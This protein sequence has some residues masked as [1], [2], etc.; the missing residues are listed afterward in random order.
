[1]R[2]NTN[3][4]IA[5]M[6]GVTITLSNFI[7]QADTI[8]MIRTTPHAA[9]L[10]S[11]GA[12]VRRTHFLAAA[13]SLAFSPLAIA[14][15]SA[16]PP[17]RVQH[18]ANFDAERKQANDLYLAGKTLESLPL[19]EDLCRQDS[20]I[21][22]FA[23]RHAGGLFAKLATL[24][25]GQEK[26]AAYNQGTAE[27]HRAQ[28]LGDNSPYVQ[29]LLGMAAKSPI[30]VAVGGPMGGSPL[31]AGYTYTGSPKAQPFFQQA[32]SDFGH[33]D[34]EGA[35]K[36]YLAAAAQ[37]PAWY[38]P[39]LDAGDMYFR[40]KNYPNAGI[41]FAKAIVID[42]DRETAYRYWGDALYRSDDPT[43]ASLKYEQAIVA[44]P[45][46]R[47]TWSGLQQWAT[48]THTRLAVPQVRR[49]DF[50]TPNGKLQIDP[51]LTT[52]T[53]DGYASWIIY[54]QARVAHGART[55]DQ[56]IMA[57]A[58]NAN[59]TFTPNGYQHTLAEEVEA[60]NAMLLNLQQKVADGVVTLDKLEPNLKILRQLKKDNMLECWILLSASDA[61]LRHDYPAYRAT[62]RH[63]LVAYIDRYIVNPQPQ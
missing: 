22:V 23:E 7:R 43:A 61:G 59:G 51:K 56:I 35:L 19:Y 2:A 14:Q 21:A 49:P 9:F 47:T 46:T 5:R 33:N 42:P 36:L 29:S 38:T 28:S 31:T 55:A 20:T 3:P 58:S 62:H 27:L 16:G 34:L 15:Q 25:N 17:L 54:E 8:G 10:R 32:E 41:W 24:P 30:G 40:L 39:D 1:M 44:E 26:Q 57:G 53:G 52:E 13:L 12:H 45:Y 63:Q 37:D 50:T 60:L 18:E 4:T 6:A 11:K 48:V